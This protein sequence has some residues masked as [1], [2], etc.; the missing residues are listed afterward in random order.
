MAYVEFTP[1]DPVWFDRFDR[2]RT[3][4]ETAVSDGLLGVFHIG[5]T[6]VPD[7]PAKPTLDAVAVFERREAMATGRDALIDTGYD[8]HRDD[9]D[10][11]VVI[12]SG[13]GD[14]VDGD[15]DDSTVGDGDCAGIDG[16][17]VCL[18]LRPL[19]HR[20]WC[21]QLVF[22]EFLRD[23]VRA[24]ATYDRTKHE[25]A[26]AHPNDVDAYTDAKEGS[27]LSLVEAAYDRGYANRLPSYAPVD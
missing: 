16:Y 5:S 8:V 14:D 17:D 21:D 13:E 23:D 7:L 3:R 12:R 22:R 15:D 18:H 24:R 26:E 10:W 4:I 2:E 25:A 6:A 11:V 20:T 1:H 19:D 27:I 9:P